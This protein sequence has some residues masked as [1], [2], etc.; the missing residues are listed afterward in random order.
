MRKALAKSGEDA[1]DSKALLLEARARLDRL[2]QAHEELLV[3][4]KN[5]GA[6]ID[7]K[8]SECTVLQ[9]QCDSLKAT[10]QTQSQRIE[11]LQLM[12]S[13]MQQTMNERSDE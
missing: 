12:A 11:E 4:S 5:M 10:K 7:E 13:R 2:S 6:E 8:R 1:R 9:E 3:S